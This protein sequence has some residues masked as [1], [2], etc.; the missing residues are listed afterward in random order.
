MAM[1]KLI[2]RCGQKVTQDQVFD[3]GDLME[4]QG[5][6]KTFINPCPINFWYYLG[7]VQNL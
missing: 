1:T 4:F 7:L 3:M 6:I 5:I 2:I